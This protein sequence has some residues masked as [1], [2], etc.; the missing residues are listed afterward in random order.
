MSKPEVSNK[1]L[2]DPLWPWRILHL[3]YI[4]VL[5]TLAFAPSSS[6]FPS[7]VCTEP[8]LDVI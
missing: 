8:E 6:G 5:N 4:L 1:Q 2:R 7:S 3:D